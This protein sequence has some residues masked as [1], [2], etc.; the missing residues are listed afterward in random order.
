MPIMGMNDVRAPIRIS[1]LRERR[2]DPA[3]ETKPPVVIW[4]IAPIRAAIRAASPVIERRLIDEI[5]AEAAPRQIGERDSY[6]LV[7]ERSG[8]ANGVNGRKRIEKGRKAGQAQPCVHPLRDQR[9]R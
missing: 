1:A 2:R 5:S 9:W 6:P 7:R 4:P 8:E 3:E